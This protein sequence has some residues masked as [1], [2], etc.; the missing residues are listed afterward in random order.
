MNVILKYMIRQVF[1][2]KIKKFVKRL[3]EVCTYKYLR[4]VNDSVNDSTLKNII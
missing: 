3:Q 4:L 2:Y 1:Y